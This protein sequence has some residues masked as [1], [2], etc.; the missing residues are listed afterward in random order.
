MFTRPPDRTGERV[1]TRR[2]AHCGGDFTP[3]RRHQK[4]CRPSCRVAHFKALDRQLR[5]LFE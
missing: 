2:C 5:V 1:R 3:V 4:F